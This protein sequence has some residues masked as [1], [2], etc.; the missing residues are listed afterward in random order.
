M[1]FILILALLM[2]YDTFMRAV[3][4]HTQPSPWVSHSTA[5]A[6]QKL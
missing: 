1:G 5:L 2:L 4:V 6:L 3:S